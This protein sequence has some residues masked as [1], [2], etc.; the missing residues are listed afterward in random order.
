MNILFIYEDNSQ[1]KTFKEKLKKIY[2]KLIRKIEVKEIINDSYKN[3]AINKIIV[4]IPIL[5]FNKVDKKFVKN[6][7]YLL[8]QN[9][10]KNV[11]L[12]KSLENKSILKNMLY[13]NNFNIINGRFL[14]KTSVVEILDYIMKNRESSLKQ[15]EISILVNENTNINLSLIKNIAKV[16]KRVNIITNNIVR[17]KKLE[18]SLYEEDGIM[19]SIGN[20]RKKGILKSKF[21]VNIDFPEELLNKYK[22]NKEAIII[23]IE[24]ECKINTKV[25]SG[26]I[27]N[28]IDIKYDNKKE[29][30][31]SLYKE[32]DK[33]KIYESSLISLDNLYEINGLKKHNNFKIVNTIGN[34]GIIHEAEYKFTKKL[35]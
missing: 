16:A 30:E 29:I 13:S 11:V 1:A 3:I 10:L 35:V 25:F 22:I 17:F 15:E 33:N 14:I 24:N 2:Y 34:N 12:A 32:F 23:N 27:V 9:N 18:K 20:N 26:V 5:K 4:S 8:K 31:T 6:L 28:N 7:I 19:I 21:I